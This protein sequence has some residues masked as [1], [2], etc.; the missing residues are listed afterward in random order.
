LLDATFSES[1]TLVVAEAGTVGVEKLDTVTRSP[2]AVPVLILRD[3]GPCGYCLL[4]G[5]GPILTELS[6]PTFAVMTHG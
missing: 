1:V 2:D 3:D 6:V 5:L 4:P